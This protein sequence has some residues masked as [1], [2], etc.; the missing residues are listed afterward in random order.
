MRVTRTLTACGLFIAAALGAT[1]SLADGRFTA[2]DVFQ[3]EYA[4]D[5][6]ISP[7]GSRVGEAGVGEVLH[8]GEAELHVL[9]GQQHEPGPHAAA[10]PGQQVP[11]AGAV[12]GARA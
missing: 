4:S 2:L 7:D 12:D 11:V 9:P 10:Q 3:L 5:P 8:G 1:P 6:Q